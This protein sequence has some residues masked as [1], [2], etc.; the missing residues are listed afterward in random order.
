MEQRKVAWDASGFAIEREESWQLA[1]G[2]TAHLV[3]LATP[4]QPTLMLFTTVGDDYLQV[5]SE[6]DLAL[7]EEILRTLRPLEQG[8]P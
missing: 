8:T 1:D 6:G 7:A 5:S 4:E 2:R 3:A